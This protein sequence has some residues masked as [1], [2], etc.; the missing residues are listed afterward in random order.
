VSAF[1]AVFG[2]DGPLPPPIHLKTTLERQL[3]PQHVVTAWSV[4]GGVISQ[5]RDG[6]RRAI[7]VESKPV[8]GKVFCVTD[9]KLDNR[10]ELQRALSVS[11]ALSDAELLLAAY[12]KWGVAVAKQLRGE[13][14]FVIWN[15]TT[16]ELF[17]ASDQLGGRHLRY[18]LRGPV[19][20][21]GSR[22]TPVAEALSGG[23]ALNE[24]LLCE[25]LEFES[26]RWFHETCF[27]QVRRVPPAHTVSVRRGEVRLDRYWIAQADPL[28]TRTSDEWVSA[29]RGKFERSVAESMVDTK[30]VAISLSGGAD[31]S[32]VT[33][34]ASQIAQRQGGLSLTAYS[35]VFE[36]TPLA[37]ERVHAQAIVRDSLGV[38]WRPVVADDDAGLDLA[39]DYSTYRLDEPELALPRSVFETRLVQAAQDG[40]RVMISGHFSD[41]LIGNTYASW[42]ALAALPFREWPREWQY[43]HR[44]I[45]TRGLAKSL[46][47][48]LASRFVVGLPASQLIISASQANILGPETFR[49]R[50]RFGT[51]SDN[52][53]VELRSPFVDLDLVELSWNLPLELQFREGVS[54][55]ILFLAIYGWPHELRARRTNAVF[56]SLVAR[57]ANRNMVHLRR[58]ADRSEVVARGWVHARQL[59]AWLDRA[60]GLDRFGTRVYR[61]LARWLGLEAFLGY[62]LTGKIGPFV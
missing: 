12:G 22:T 27:E 52:F 49:I 8:S 35:S 51:L 36:R 14:A 5:V 38:R 9:S 21:I 25:L 2:Y 59:H 3:A 39:A 28:R 37:D 16:R 32:A 48:R 34:V 47:G 23:T 46:V 41:S 7:S 17:G 61:P 26:P 30:A 58:L 31:S 24:S 19:C 18:S 45:G 60:A 4:P 29:F 56:G 53:G 50:T 44:K 55:R 42:R 43:F 11:D 1:L 54:K 10:A 62:R 15:A 20:A 57:G 13:F 33:L 6:W 40:H